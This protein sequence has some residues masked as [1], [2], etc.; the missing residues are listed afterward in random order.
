MIDGLE[1][2]ISSMHHAVKFITYNT[3][4]PLDKRHNVIRSTVPCIVGRLS[5]SQRLT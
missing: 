5:L 1:L 3:L 2:K 4:E